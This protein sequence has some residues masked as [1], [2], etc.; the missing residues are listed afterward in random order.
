MKKLRI[1]YLVISIVALSMF[2]N[3]IL[4]ILHAPRILILLTFISRDV[5]TLTLF[6]LI[7][8]SSRY[9][10]R[11]SLLLCWTIASFPFAISFVVFDELPLLALV[12]KFR[13]IYT[14]PLFCFLIISKKRYEINILPYL[15][16]FGSICLFEAFFI[17]TSNGQ[18]Y[19]N[20]INFHSYMASKGTQVGY[21]FGIFGQHR[22]LTPMFQ[23]SLGGLVLACTIITL[24]R[25]R[26]FYFA[27]V[28]LLPLIL[29]LSKTGIVL[30]MV[31]GCIYILPNVTLITIAVAPFLL[32]NFISIL[33]TTHTG[34]ILYHFKGYFEG[35]KY[36]IEPQGVG[37]TGTVASLPG[38]QVGAESGIGSYLA[39]FGFYGLFPLL[40]ALVSKRENIYTAFFISILFTEITMNLYVLVIFLLLISQRDTYANN[41]E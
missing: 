33:D 3:M 32:I 25:Y 15:Y 1:Y 13:N 28:L 8:C 22:L 29:T 16:L 5:I 2:A 34:S 41:T 37:N 31:Y 36:L 10:I 39:A 11:L 14:V 18:F 20:L 38:R 4:S 23:P 30:V 21:G 17:V 19:L 26:R 40:L 24:A 12:E 27:A 35:F 7:L 6:L 9:N